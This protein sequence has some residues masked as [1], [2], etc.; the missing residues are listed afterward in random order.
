M[1]SVLRY[2]SVKKDG[3][4]LFLKPETPC[5]N[6]GTK[7]VLFPFSYLNGVLDI[8]YS[9][10]NFKEIM[11]DNTGED[12]K[13]D[14]ETGVAIR[15]MG[16]VFLVTS[17]GENFKA[18]I[19]SWRS[20]TIDAGSPITIYT[21][22]QIVRVQQASFTN[23]N[24]DGESYTISNQPPASDTYPTGSVAND[25]ETTFIFK[26][27]LTFTIYES[28]VVKYITFKTDVDQE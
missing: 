14:S 12:V 16:G 25:Y 13:P 21:Y 9:G 8:S 4:T 18:Y 15:M 28:G 11:V 7:R 5:Y 10:N 23:V 3:L 22:P 2:F 26:T 17:L 6:D 27:P 24:A 20:P 1:T 19:R